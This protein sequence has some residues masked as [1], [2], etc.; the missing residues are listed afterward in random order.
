MA[1]TTDT[2]EIHKTIREYYEQLHANKLDNLEEMDN[3]PEIY[4]LP[5]LNQ[6]EIDQ[7]NRPITRNEIEY[8]IK[9]LSTNKSPGPDG[10][11]GEFYQTYKEELVPILLKLF[12]KVEEEGTFPKTFY[13]AT[14]A[15]ILKP[16]I[17]PKKENHRPIFLMNIEAKILKKSFIQLKVLSKSKNLEKR[18]YTKTKGDSFQVHKDCSKNN[19]CHTHIK[20]SKKTT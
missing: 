20:K 3:F 17:L 6:E 16:K 12:Q 14:I 13:E 4:S 10:F 7:L 5:T 1:I 18:S 19:Q 8:V 15:L 11:I 2:A 9:T